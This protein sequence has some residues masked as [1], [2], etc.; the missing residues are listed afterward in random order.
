MLSGLELLTSPSWRDYELLDSGGGRKLERFGPHIFVRPEHQ[1]VWQRTL[2]E[3]RWQAAQGVFEPGGGDEMGGKWQF[4]QKVA[5]AWE[6]TYGALRFKAQMSTSRHMG[7][8]PEQAAHWEWMAERIRTANG[9]VNVLNLFGYTGLATLACAAAGAKVTHVDASKKAVGWAR[10]NQALSALGERPIRWIVDDALKFVLRE[11]RRRVSYDAIVL[12]PPKFGRGPKGEIWDCLQM[13][14]ELLAACR[15]VLS[16]R[17]LFVV[18]TAYAIRA[19]AASLYFALQ[20]MTAGLGGSA[21]A[22]ELAT[23]EKSAGRVLSNAIF[24]RWRSA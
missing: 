24:A 12:D 11:N 5:P 2:P 23:I 22:G 9:P 3:A 7:V 15:A 17:P 18:L 4:R 19:S 10:E 20:E 13:L 6:M 8:F 14:P 16:P 1:A 21:A